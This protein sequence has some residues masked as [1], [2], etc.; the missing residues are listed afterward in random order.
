LFKVEHVPAKKLEPKYDYDE[1]LAF[2]EK[3]SK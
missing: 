2:K 1:P 3:D